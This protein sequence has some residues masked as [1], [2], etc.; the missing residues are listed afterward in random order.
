M[1]HPGDGD[2]GGRRRHARPLL[3]SDGFRNAARDGGDPRQAVNAVSTRSDC[4]A[5]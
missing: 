4:L 2:R 3:T 1:A 5:K